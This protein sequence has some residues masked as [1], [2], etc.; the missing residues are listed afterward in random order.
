MMAFGSGVCVWAANA[1]EKSWP[2]RVQDELV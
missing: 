1:F 2:G